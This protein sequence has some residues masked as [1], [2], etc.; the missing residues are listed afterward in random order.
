MLDPEVDPAVM[1]EVREYV[2][3]GPRTKRWQVESSPR[4]WADLVAGRQ[5]F[6]IQG[7]YDH[8]SVKRGRVVHMQ[9]VYCFTIP[10]LR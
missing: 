4:S 3:P 1:G 6:S 2:G 9:I 10:F 7:S 8:F 5:H